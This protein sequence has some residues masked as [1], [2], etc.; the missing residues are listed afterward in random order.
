MTILA[1]AAAVL[2]ILE[3]AT[4]EGPALLSFVQSAVSAVEATG[5]SGTD[6]MTAV[7]NATEAFVADLVPSL[8]TPLEKLMEAVEAFVNDLVAVYNAAGV[9]VSAVKAAV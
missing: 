9:F 3:E 8:V 6:K 4:I 7:L 2:D 1:T 5:K